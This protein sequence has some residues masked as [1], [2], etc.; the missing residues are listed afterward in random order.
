MSLFSSLPTTTLNV[1]GMHCE[2]CVA[3]VKDALEAIDGV[4][5]AQVDLSSNSAT[6]TGDVD[7][8]AMVAAIEAIGFGASVA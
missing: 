6:V 5:G 3:R 1:T 2:K 8:A 4:T 7:A